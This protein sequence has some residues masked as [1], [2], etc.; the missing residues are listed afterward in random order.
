LTIRNDEGVS[1]G[2]WGFDD[3]SLEAGIQQ[4][5][6]TLPYLPL[7]PGTYTIICSLFNDGNNLTGGKLIE[8]WN[9]VPFL[10]VDTLP[11]SHHQDAWAGILNIPAN[12][13]IGVRAENQNEGREQHV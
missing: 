8:L 11:L 7:R 6:F 13:E 9:A 12:L 2:G 5:R 1:V 10:A 4:L 3:F